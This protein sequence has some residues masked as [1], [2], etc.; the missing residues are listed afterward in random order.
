MNLIEIE[1]IE[2][3]LTHFGDTKKIEYIKMD[4]LAKGH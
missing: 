2:I 3:L 1:K 4:D